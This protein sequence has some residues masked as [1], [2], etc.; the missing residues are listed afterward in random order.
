[1]S[2]AIGRRLRRTA[3]PLVPLTALTLD[4][5]C[6]GRVDRFERVHAV[7]RRGRRRGAWPVVTRAGDRPVLAAMAL[8][9]AAVAHRRGRSGWQPV[10]PVLA[11][12]GLRAGLMLAVGRDRPP[13]DRWLTEPGGASFPSRHVTCCALGLMALRDALPASPALDAV[14]AGVLVVTGYSRW[15]LGVHWPSDVLGGLLLAAAVHAA[16]TD[17]RTD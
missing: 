17:P 1:V 16:L 4:V 2:A 12:V 9:A 5:A 6:H 3:L 15:R 10:R 11:G 7:P 8:A 13:R 14:G